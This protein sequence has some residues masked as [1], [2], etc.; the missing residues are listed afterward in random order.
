MIVRGLGELAI[1]GR[2]LLFCTLLGMLFGLS[3]GSL[4][5]ESALPHIGPAP[6]FTLTDQDG[7]P[8]S[9]GKH[10]GKVAVVTFVFA[11]CS[12]TCPLLTAKLVGIQRKLARAAPELIFTAITVDPLNDTPA[13]LKEYATR[14]SANLVN[15]AFL[16]GSP[17]QIEEVAHR[18]AV[19][20]KK[21]DN[22][23]T[24]HSFLTSLI[25]RQGTLRVQYLG[26]KFDPQEFEADL[27]SLLAEGAK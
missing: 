22:G 10:K 25:D 4:A 7:R 2:V 21:Q 6:Q 9:L 14:Y 23:N 27:R 5:N 11:G 18:Y 1:R 8:F 20:R 3:W 24:D 17:N 16:T 26:A 12:D 15:F 19:F 13:M